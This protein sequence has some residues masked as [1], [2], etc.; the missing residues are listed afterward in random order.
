MFR[1]LL[2]DD[3]KLI[4]TAVRE[5]LQGIQGVSVV[6]EAADGEAAVS[7]IILDRPDLVI[8]DVEMP[9]M[10][11][12]SVLRELR[13]RGIE[14]PILMLSSL[15]QTGADVTFRALELGA[16]DFVP[17][18]S[19]GAGVTAEEAARRLVARVSDLAEAHREA[20]PVSLVR[21]G[22]RPLE[23]PHGSTGTPPVS[24]SAPEQLP[25][26]PDCRLLVIGVSTG[27]PNALSQ[28]F[29][30]LG[31]A[32]PVPTIVVQ[33][34]PPLF[35]AAFAQRLNQLGPTRVTEAGDGMLLEAGCAYVAPGD[36][37]VVLEESTAGLAARLDSGERVNGH[38]PSVDITLLSAV[39]VL[40]SSVAGVIM[41][42]MGRD[43]A[44][45]MT[46]LR[47]AGGATLAQ[48]AA[49]SAVYGMN[50]RAIEEGGV[51]WVL[52]LDRIAEALLCLWPERQGGS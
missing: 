23:A 29:A 12:L 50:R 32:L 1:V 16:L 52:P 14:L 48:D 17:K 4:R 11:G 35:T 7:R 31:R 9:R 33:H 37:H 51:Q 10:D 41:T 34:M 13:G 6:A 36:R 40:S 22:R 42:G 27:G 38:R 49:T 39:E 25:A 28:I 2:V 19:P 47:K 20:T 30:G 24:D 44:H 5:A 26:R 18:P 3:S 21:T 46:A 43:G 15:T 45:G 8:M